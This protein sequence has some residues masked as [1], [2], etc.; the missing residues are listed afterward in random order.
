[1]LE[2]EKKRGKEKAKEAEVKTKLEEREKHGRIAN[3][4]KSR[5]E[6]ANEA[7]KARESAGDRRK[8]LRRHES[9]DEEVRVLCARARACKQHF[10]FISFHPNM[11]ESALSLGVRPF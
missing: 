1:M 4:V 6:E 2:Q 9:S 8:W 11:L 5:E 10:I 7:K 3:D